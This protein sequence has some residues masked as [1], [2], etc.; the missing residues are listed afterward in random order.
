MILSFTNAECGI[1]TVSSE[2]VGPYIING[3]RAARGAW[4]W[5]VVVYTGIYSFGQ[6]ERLTLCGGTLINDRWVLTA[7]HCIRVEE[8]DESSSYLGSV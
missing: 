3:Q 8:D 5:Q 1:R 6:F 7:A 4:P 2:S